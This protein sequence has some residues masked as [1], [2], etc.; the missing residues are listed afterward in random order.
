MTIKEFVLSLL[1]DAGVAL[2]SPEVR[3]LETPSL[4]IPFPDSLSSS[5]RNNLMT[6]EAAK[7]NSTVAAHFKKQVYD[8]VDAE[9]KKIMDELGLDDTVKTEL[10]SE[11][12]STQRIGK[13]AKTIRDLEAAK[14]AA[15]APDKKEIQKLIDAKVEEFKVKEKQYQDQLSAKDA[16][17]DSELTNY[18]ID[19]ILAQN[20]YAVPEGFELADILSL[21]KGKVTKALQDAGVKVVRENGTLKLV[22]EADG[23]DYMSGNDK[24][25]F[26]TFSNK[27]LAN[28]KILKTAETKTTGSGGTGGGDNKR[29]IDPG[30]KGNADAVSELD[31]QRKIMQASV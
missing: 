23:L 16:Q 2:D 19:N 1:K 26:K 18:A 10:L 28:A 31:E 4:D 12:S 25:D 30:K 29:V 3:A 17:H 5:I 14:A 7:N 6:V 22:K 9:T 15:A 27:V 11:K 24:V 13:L 20:Q 21:G 8:G